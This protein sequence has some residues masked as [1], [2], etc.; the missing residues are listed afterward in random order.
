V[1]GAI[2][3]VPL[4]LASFLLVLVAADLAMKIRAFDGGLQACMRA[5]ILVGS[6][7]LV[8]GMGN[9][10]DENGVILSCPED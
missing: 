2:T 4:K 5:M 9:T 6:I 7:C 8:F 10:L 1:V 3:C